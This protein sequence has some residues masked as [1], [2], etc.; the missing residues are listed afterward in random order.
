[1][2]P[3]IIKK[4]CCSFKCLFRCCISMQV[5]GQL[6]LNSHYLQWQC[7]W[8]SERARERVLKI[9]WR[10]KQLKNDSDPLV[11]KWK[12]R[13][14]KV[15]WEITVHNRCKQETV[16]E[17]NVSL[18]TAFTCEKKK[19]KEYN[20]KKKKTPTTC[21]CRWNTDI[22][23]YHVVRPKKYFHLLISCYKYNRTKSQ[24]LVLV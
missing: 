23:C 17:L 15:Y 9:N 14:H 13:V 12:S 24:T 16:W 7:E 11:W 6:N 3:N 20:N 1:M 10:E 22:L 2:R 19:K 4:V 5:T 8:W 18:V 21:C